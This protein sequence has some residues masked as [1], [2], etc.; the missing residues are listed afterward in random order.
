M[1]YLDV[2]AEG[3]VGEAGTE[4]LSQAPRRP[5]GVVGVGIVGVGGVMGLEFKGPERRGEGRGGGTSF[6]F[7]ERRVER[8]E[9]VGEADWERRA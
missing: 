5:R 6:S 8:L 9:G 2:A 7:W 4:R 3:V 1:T